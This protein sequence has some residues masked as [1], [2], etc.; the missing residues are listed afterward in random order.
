MRL[1]NIFLTLLF[2]TGI[3]ATLATSRLS[4]EI[5]APG[6][7]TEAK[8]VY[9]LPGSSLKMIEA[10]LFNAGVIGDRLSFT[11]AARWKN[12]HK[13]LK[14]GEYQFP[15]GAN[16]ADVITLLQSG[17]T[18]QHKIT[19]PEGLTVAEIA[20][21]LKAEPGLS[22]DIA[23]NPPEGS[24]LPETYSFSY[25]DTRAGLIVRM[26]I[27]M[28]EEL[29]ELWDKRALDVP[30][31][32]PQEAVILASIVEKETG[33]RDER[34]R[35]ASVFINRLNKKM[36][37]QSDPTVIYAITGGQGK[38][39]RA[40]TY[41]DLKEP[42]DYNTYLVQGLPPTPI[43]NPGRASLHA[44]LNPEKS[45][46]IYFVADGS[47]GHAFSKTLKEHNNNVKLWRKMQKKAK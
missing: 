20:E 45:D 22:G 38:M 42:S 28:Q 18:Y 3:A 29:K 25:R 2:V 36:P 33:F 17:K 16:I 11:I 10:K 31:T 32:T 4:R 46:Y 30:F 9:I 44:V 40:L 15:A 7:L 43:A 21:L 19:I 5:N 13:A 41:A 39:D 6:P 23:E 35:A 8:L 14:S 27:S 24:L 26:Q 34:S 1:L 37:L 12:R 47:G